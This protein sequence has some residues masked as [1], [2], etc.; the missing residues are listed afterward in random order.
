M[1]GMIA[2]VLSSN[3]AQAINQ[4]VLEIVMV[5]PRVRLREISSFV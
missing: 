2:R 3:P 1:N 4:W 5:V